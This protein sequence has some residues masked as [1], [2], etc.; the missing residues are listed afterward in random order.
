M[1][2]APPPYLSDR[3]VERIDAAARDLIATERP[4]VLA[5][6]GGRDSMVMLHAVHQALSA[7]VPQARRAPSVRVATFDH[8]TGPAA[9][10]ATALVAEEASRL[11][12]SVCVGHAPTRGKTEAE[13]RAARWSFLRSVTPNGGTIVTAHTHDD[14]VETVV[15]RALRG[16][17]ARGLAGLAPASTAIA[18]PLLHVS[19]ATVAHYAEMNAV[20]YIDDP[21]N[22]SRA[23]LRNRVRLDLLPAVRALRPRFEG[24]MAMLADRAAALR[25]D[26][27]RVVG[28]YLVHGP[29][30]EGFLVARDELTTYDSAALSVLWPAIAAR[31]GVTLDRRGTLRLTQFTKVGAPGA[32]MQLS[33]GVEVYR[34]RDASRDGFVFRRMTGR[35][36]VD[37]TVPLEGVVDFGN[38]RFRPASRLHSQSE[39]AE[40]SRETSRRTRTVGSDNAWTADLPAD[41]RLTVREWRPGDRM[42]PGLARPAR[43]VKRYFGDARIPGP[44]RAGWPVV[45][46]DDEIVW[47]PGVRR[48][49][50]APERSGRPMIRYI[51][52]RFDGGP[53]YV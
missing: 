28:R 18:R 12:L 13:W 51:C 26:V 21:S 9:A 46:A 7:P 19:R 14:H 35:P 31:A 5:V 48:V 53:A 20:P 10:T 22:Q 27:D 8:G 11:G 29:A 2:A 36:A 52:E 39:T 34:H 33:G 23:H 44:S 43:R 37:M 50:A 17:G 45:L 47:I 38:W 24:E 41:R 4:L 16:A 3:N 32:R 6:S 40:R 1:R 49:R 25:A 42:R 30:T 15:M